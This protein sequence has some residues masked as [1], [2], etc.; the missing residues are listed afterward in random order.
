VDQTLS[1]KTGGERLWSVND[2]AD[3]LRLKPETV[4]I[5]AR[6]GELPVFKLGKRLWR[7]D[8]S[9]IQAWVDERKNA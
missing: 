7:F 5:M 4:R 2:V 1:S 3:Y 9:E 8:A 6:K